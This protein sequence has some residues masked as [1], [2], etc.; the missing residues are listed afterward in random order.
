L[1]V[2]RGGGEE[3]KERL[4]KAEGV[5]LALPKRGG[6]FTDQKQD[7]RIRYYENLRGPREKGREERKKRRALFDRKTRSGKKTWTVRYTSFACGRDVR[8]FFRAVNKKGTVVGRGPAK[9][10]GG[11]TREGGLARGQDRIRLKHE[12]GIQA[13]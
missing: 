6:R 13:Q 10:R 9:G 3:S 7:S 1:G 12:W 2:R 4:P 8:P 11:Y 5:F